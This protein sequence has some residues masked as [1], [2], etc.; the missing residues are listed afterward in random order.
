MKTYTC[1][2]CG[3][4]NLEEP[5]FDYAIC[6]SCGTEFGYTDAKRAHETL[7]QLWIANGKVWYSRVTP[8]PLNWDPDK[9]LANVWTP[10]STSIEVDYGNVVVAGNNTIFTTEAVGFDFRGAFLQ[11]SSFLAS[12]PSFVPAT[13]QE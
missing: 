5:P 6:P 7:R 2:V 13:V 12:K 4:D 1:P 9:Q 11:V 8:R 3:Y 10:L